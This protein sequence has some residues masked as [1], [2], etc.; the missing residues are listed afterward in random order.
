M[1]RHDAIRSRS[2][3]WEDDPGVHRGTT[4]AILSSL[5]INPW[6]WKFQSEPRTE[7]RW[8]LPASTRRIWKLYLP[9]TENHVDWVFD[10]F[11]SVY[12]WT[13]LCCGLLCSNWVLMNYLSG[14]SFYCCTRVEINLANIIGVDDCPD[15]ISTSHRALCSFINL[16][17]I[18]LYHNNNELSTTLFY[19]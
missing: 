19:S 13:T 9:I 7:Y 2:R 8:N 10:L 1:S 12:F 11:H 6:C 14:S 16:F 5:G 15:T 17:I 18:T 3:C 4:I